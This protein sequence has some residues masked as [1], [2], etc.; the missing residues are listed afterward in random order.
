MAYDA[1]YV[2]RV[3]PYLEVN[4]KVE[5]LRTTID[6]AKSTVWSRIDRRLSRKLSGFG[7][8]IFGDQGGVAGVSLVKPH[9]LS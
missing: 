7:L 8:T 9:R 5:P 4:L 1:M 6:H 2:W 3:K